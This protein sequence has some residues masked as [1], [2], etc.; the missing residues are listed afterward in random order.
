MP[1]LCTSMLSQRTAIWEQRYDGQIKDKG[2]SRSGSSSVISQIPNQLFTHTKILAEGK[3]AFLFHGKYFP[4]LTVNVVQSHVAMKYLQPFSYLVIIRFIL[5]D[6]VDCI[7]FMNIA[8]I[9]GIG[10]QYSNY[11]RLP[12]FH[13]EALITILMTMNAFTV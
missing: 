3:I 8:L 13:K 6:F 11:R 10:K 7:K 12:N 1:S 9:Q 4:R 5:I 2:R